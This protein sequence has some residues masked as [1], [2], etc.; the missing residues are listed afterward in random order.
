MSLAAVGSLWL[1]GLASLT[2][3]FLGSAVKVSGL[4]LPAVGKT[5]ARVGVF[6][7]GL[8]SLLLG[9]VIFLRQDAGDSPTGG[10]QP[11]TG[12]GHPS[13]TDWL[14]PLPR[15]Q[16]RPAASKTPPCCGTERCAW[17]TAPV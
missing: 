12:S 1:F 8:V 9:T 7:I 5:P 4:E 2:V 6:A 10:A 17:T 15:I 11:S 3:A 14:R 16:P 13:A